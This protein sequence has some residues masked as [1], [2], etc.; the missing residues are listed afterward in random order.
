MALLLV[1]VETGLVIYIIYVHVS[2]V[3]S[4]LPLCVGRVN[5]LQD[6]V[7]PFFLHCLAGLATAVFYRTSL[8]HL[9]K[10][11]PPLA[12]RRDDVS[13]NYAQLSLITYNHTYIVSI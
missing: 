3:A 13:R 1:N 8:R 2:F 12:A 6:T 5:E 9:T 10:N 7:W 11:L 4:C